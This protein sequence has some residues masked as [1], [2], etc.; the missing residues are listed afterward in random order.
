M[1]QFIRANDEGSNVLDYD[2]L[3]TAARIN[4]IVAAHRWATEIEVDLDS[5]PDASNAEKVEAIDD[6]V[7]ATVRA[8]FDYLYTDDGADVE[9][10]QDTRLMIEDIISSDLAERYEL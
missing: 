3:D 9:I 2:L 7:H 10:D 4:L 8:T 5:E 1:Q 6:Q